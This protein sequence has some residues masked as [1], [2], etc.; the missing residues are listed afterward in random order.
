MRYPRG[1]DKEVRTRLAEPPRATPLETETGTRCACRLL[2]SCSVGETERALFTPVALERQGARVRATGT[3][4]SFP[5]TPARPW[6]D[7]GAAEAL[8]CRDHAISRGIY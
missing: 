6:Q 5:Q 1:A 4:P 8:F 2:V 3:A 7:D